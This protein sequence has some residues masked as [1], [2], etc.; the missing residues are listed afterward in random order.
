METFHE[1]YKRLE[2]KPKMKTFITKSTFG[3]FPFKDLLYLA[4]D[5]KS[6]ERV[7][8]TSVGDEFIHESF[9]QSP[10]YFR[11]SDEQNMFC[12]DWQRILQNNVTSP[13][14]IF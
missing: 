10:L 2:K 4:T 11:H 1:I 8:D 14:L 5:S 7:G 12:L 6:L 3:K 9:V 13:E